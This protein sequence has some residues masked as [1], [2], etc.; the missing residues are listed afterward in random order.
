[1]LAEDGLSHTIWWWWVIL[2]A[3]GC[4]GA[5]KLIVGRLAE[6]TGLLASTIGGLVSIG[7]LDNMLGVGRLA[8]PCLLATLNGGSMGLNIPFGRRPKG[9]IL[10]QGAIE[11]AAA[12]AV[13]FW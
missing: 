11:A 9:N 12:A 7:G 8:T 13:A 1:M 6:V 5:G 10:S 3:V 4:D 2:T